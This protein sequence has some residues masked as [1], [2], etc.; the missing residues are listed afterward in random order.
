[1]RRLVIVL[2]ISSN[3]TQLAQYAEGM[4][5]IVY[6]AWRSFFFRS[7][8]MANTSNVRANC[9]RKRKKSA[10]ARVRTKEKA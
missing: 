6:I 1:M 4:R 7:S 5:P 10:M 8:Q 9:A 2:T 3:D